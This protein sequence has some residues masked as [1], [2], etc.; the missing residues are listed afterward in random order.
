M[1]ICK[2]KRRLQKTLFTAVLLLA[3]LEMIFMACTNPAGSGDDETPFTITVG[4]LG[5]DYMFKQV[6]AGTVNVNVDYFDKNA[7]SKGPFS[8]A[9]A[10]NVSIS[11]FYIGET[12]IP[13]ELWHAVRTWAGSNGYSFANEGMEGNDGTEGAAPTEAKLEPVTYISWRDAV[14]WCNAYS[15]AQGRQPVY[16]LAGTTDFND[17]TKVLR[18]SE[19]DTVIAKNGKAENAV[20]NGSANGFRLPGEAE[21]EYAARGGAPGTAPWTYTYAGSNDAPVVA[22]YETSSTARVK[23]RAA[24]SRGLYDMGGNVYEWCQDVY[25]DSEIQLRVMRGGCFLYGKNLCAL[26]ARSNAAPA[27]KYINVGFRVATRS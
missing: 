9:A 7:P 23:S 14:V 21:W 26:A 11:A 10:L 5:L 2:M 4:A 16:Y 24:N 15:E 6:P 1:E 25:W 13:Y 20:I 8:D 18:E 19:D 3:A 12:E 22:V 17:T 27:E